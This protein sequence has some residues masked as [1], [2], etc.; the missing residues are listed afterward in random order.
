MLF[1]YWRELMNSSKYLCALTLRY[2]F[3]VV[4]R[5]VISL[6]VVLNIWFRSFLNLRSVM[7]FYNRFGL[8]S[9]SAN[10]CMI[11]ASLPLN[12][13]WHTNTPV[14]GFLANSWVIRLFN[15]PISF[16]PMSPLVNPKSYNI[17]IINIL[18]L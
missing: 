5:I 18:L 13:N 2:I 17:I 9:Y 12:A 8:M 10:V 4:L 11:N 16:S 6:M 3:I 1:P 7:R 14:M 15:Y